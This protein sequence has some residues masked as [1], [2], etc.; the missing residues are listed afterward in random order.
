[1]PTQ[2]SLN[3]PNCGAPRRG[4]RCE[5]CGTAFLFCAWDR[6]QDV[7]LTIDSTDLEETMLDV[8]NEAV[9]RFLWEV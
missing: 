5:Y 2:T 3:C 9:T 1:M 8:S 6:I 7:T 4:T